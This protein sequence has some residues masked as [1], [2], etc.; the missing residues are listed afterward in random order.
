MNG[1]N[2]ECRTIVM[3]YLLHYCYKNT[4]KSLLKELRTLDNCAEAIDS[5][6]CSIMFIIYIIERINLFTLLY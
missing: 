6:K 3:E 4:A 5:N 1:H 2:E